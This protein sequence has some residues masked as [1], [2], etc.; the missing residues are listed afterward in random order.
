MSHCVLYYSFCIGEQ[1]G[2]GGEVRVFASLH[3]CSLGSNRV[4]KVEF[5]NGSLLAPSAF[6]RILW[7]S[8]L[9]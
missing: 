8:F 6:L 1:E 3:R 4:D 2:R 9:L 5:V 7:F